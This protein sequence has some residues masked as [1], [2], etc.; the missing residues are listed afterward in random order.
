MFWLHR[1]DAIFYYDEQHGIVPQHFKNYSISETPFSGKHIP[2]ADVDK[3]SCLVVTKRIFKESTHSDHLTKIILPDLPLD[4]NGM[5][6]F[7]TH[8]DSKLSLVNLNLHDHFH[9]L[10]G[11]NRNDQLQLACLLISINN[12]LLVRDIGITCAE[13]C[14]KILYSCFNN[15][16]L[17][18]R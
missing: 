9:C 7:P 12:D 16:P 14:L 8:V 5:S 4:L 13:Y 2:W 11:L 17:T 15:T 1:Y 6:I 3:I 10:R 18:Q